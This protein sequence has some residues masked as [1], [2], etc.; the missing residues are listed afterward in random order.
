MRFINPSFLYLLPLVSVPIIIH[1][2][3]RQRYKKI[4]F[5]SLRFLRELET[6]VIRRLKL[7]QIIL[8][9]L[10]T[11][12]ILLL[13]LIFARPY[14]SSV[15][16]SMA[17]ST[18]ETLYLLI[19]NS[20]SM[21]GI[22]QGKSL[23]EVGNESIK[24][25]IGEIAFPIILKSVESVNSDIIQNY[26]LISSH[27][28]MENA[29][30]RFP[31]KPSYGAIDKA[32][33]SIQKEIKRNEESSVSI[34]I[35]SDFQENS[36]E[37]LNLAEHPIF[38]LAQREGI[39]IILL[40]VFHRENNIAINEVILPDQINE[41]G[42]SSLVK[43][44]LEN[45][46]EDRSE[47]SV[48]LFLKG[49]RIGQTVAELQANGQR[50]VIFEFIPMVTGNLEGKAVIQDDALLN[51]NE[52]FFILNIP[53]TIRVLIVGTDIDD[54][55]FIQNAL[56][57]GGSSVIKSKI[58]STGLLPIENLQ[59]YDVIFFSNVSNIQPSLK[60][61]ISE[62]LENGKGVILFLGDKCT[63]EDYNDFWAKEFSFPRWKDIRQA[64]EETF[65][66][67]GEFQYDHPIFKGLWIEEKPSIGSPYFYRIPGFL[68]GK[69]HSIIA[70]YNEGTPFMIESVYNNTKAL[71]FATS[72]DIEWT[73]F[74]LTGLFP[75]LM[76]RITLYMSGN[77]LRSEEY[78]TG[79][80]VEFEIMDKEL[81][82]SPVVITPTGKKFMPEY[83]K[84]RGKY[85]FCETSEP[86]CYEVKLR[87]IA[88]KNFIVN[89]S[90]EESGG[91]FLSID[92]LK[93]I[94][95]VKPSKIAIAESDGSE[96]LSGLRTTN[97]Y[98][99]LLIVFALIIALLE[100]YIGRVNRIEV[101]KQELNKAG[102]IFMSTNRDNEL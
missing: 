30:D 6:D 86:G 47:V 15:A 62:F 24:S 76:Q 11:L 49:E 4:E 93:D 95:E 89:I 48:S 3:G 45:W 73:D 102:G 74:H 52:R 67:I 35:L 75:V 31:V 94:A 25:A 38:T 70:N 92:E 9:I 13:I 14:R 61:T 85:R 46:S 69:N 12:L 32:L 42:K 99:N 50:E 26:D 98:T 90:P 29:L 81:F 19:D 33:L 64:S 80:T 59:D 40:P 34:W 88:V 82:D 10:R 23:L 37:S 53:E 41:K 7:R 71:V 44:H 58:T 22:S 101:E 18:G 8:L 63:P 68:I 65:L 51:D 79:D 97:E 2:L 43:V 20:S 27:S 56:T 78:F 91:K 16:P 5:S 55:K 72:P 66:K 60:T 54:G 87:G 57:S 28:Q 84:K 21:S 96:E 39:R 100:M 77:S 83:V 17:L 1:L 36:W